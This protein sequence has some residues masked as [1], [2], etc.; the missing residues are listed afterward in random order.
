MGHGANV[1]LAICVA[2]AFIGW[3]LSP[4]FAQQAQSEWQGPQSRQTEPVPSPSQ[5]ATQSTPQPVPPAPAQ[6]LGAD[7]P[8]VP[9][10]P[11]PQAAP[12]SSQ[13]PSNTTSQPTTITSQPPAPSPPPQPAAALTKQRRS[14]N[15]PY[16]GAVG[17]TGLACRYPA[18]VR[19]SRVIENSPAYHAG[20]KGEATLTWKDA[21]ANILAVS[22]IAPFLSS[23][24]G[25]SEHGGHGDLILA[26][27]GKRV[28]NIEEFNRELQRCRPGDV[29]YLSVL[30]GE[31][32]LIQIPVRLS[33]YPTGDTTVAAPAPAAP[34]LPQASVTEQPIPGS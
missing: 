9:E 32:G 24:E 17:K 25:P 10:M 27:D 1:R 22:P 21:M 14:L 19:V 8:Q 13:K 33:E 23:G 12:A 3:S 31:R 5:P 26:V 34:P 7:H 30:R 11:R 28:H 18:G 16:F 15:P 29:V 6:P 2:L 20:L 4:L